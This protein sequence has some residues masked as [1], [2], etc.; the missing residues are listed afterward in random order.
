MTNTNANYFN[1][2]KR[3]PQNMLV[4]VGKIPESLTNIYLATILKRQINVKAESK[5]YDIETM[6]K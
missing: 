6:F 4:K 3:N 5:G 2:E 1:P